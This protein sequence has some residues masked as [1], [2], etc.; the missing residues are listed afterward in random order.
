MRITDLMILLI[1]FATVMTSVSF[2]IAGL[3]I[4]YPGASNY[5]QTY[6][7]NQYS[8]IVAAQADKSQTAAGIAGANT[9]L[10]STGTTTNPY[11]NIFV[12]G[13]N[14]LKDLTSIGPDITKVQS[15]LQSTTKKSG[16]PVPLYIWAGIAA[17]IAIIILATLINAAQRVVV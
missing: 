7:P 1:L 6:N 8:A 16:L 2:Y 12:A 5:T 9:Q 4:Q 15:T 11:Q 10:T 14:A 17:I 3:D 13:W